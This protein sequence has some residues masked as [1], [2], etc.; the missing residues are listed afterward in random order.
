MKA[1]H[2]GRRRGRG[3]LLLSLLLYLPMA[4]S[5]S[6]SLASC[7]LERL[8]LQPWLRVFEDARADMS[9]EQI[10]ALP[11][12][13]LSAATAHLLAPGY[14]RSAFWLRL[15][16]ENR[17]GQACQW[18]LFP[19]SA[20]ARDMILHQQEAGGWSRQVAG[21]WH[22]LAEWTMPTR[23]PAFEVGLP[24]G[25]SKVLWLRLASDYAF[26]MQPMLLSHTGLL[27]ERMAESLADGLV[28]GIV[29]LLVIFSLALGRIFRLPL[30]VAHAMSMLAYCLNVALA[31]GYGFV[32]LW[33]TAMEW[34]GRAILL[35]SAL[36]RILV[37]AYLRILLLV[38][39]QPPFCGYFLTCCQ[40]AIGGLAVGHALW[41]EVE[42]LAPGAWPGMLAVVAALLGIAGA[43]LVGHRQKLPYDWFCY[44]V[45]GLI[46]LQAL[47]IYAFLFGLASR[48]PAEYSWLSLST[49]YGGALLCYTLVSQTARSRGREQRVL[50]DIEQLKR[51]EQERLE[52][53]V[54]VRTAQ[55]RDSLR[56]QNLLL[57]RI[58]H[59][60]RSP[61][62]G[63]LE[64]ARRLQARPAGLADYS[65][66]IEHSVRHQLELIDELLEYSRGE[67][68]QLELL[69]APGYLFGFLREIEEQGRFLAERNHNR[70]ECHFANDLPPLVNA[71]FRRL[72]QI[73]VNLLANAGK[74]TCDGCIVLYVASLMSVTAGR[75]KLYFSVADSGIGIA[76]A[77]RERLL[78]PFSRGSNAGDREGCG[79]GLY[80]VRQLLGS[81]GS[82][83]LIDES[84]LGGSQFSFVLE[85]DLA[86][87]QQLEQVYIESH[88]AT[89]EGYDRR[90]LIVDD[91]LVSREM[92]RELLAGYGYDPLACGSGEE[93]LALLAAEPVDLLILDQ[94]MPGM[95]GW[96]VLAEVRRCWPD[97]PVLLYS[98]SPPLRPSSLPGH[99]EFDACLLKPANSG[100]LLS[101]LALL[102]PTVPDRAS[103]EV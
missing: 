14:S 63:M 84:D 13:R 102:L 89:G 16:L 35:S 31:T 92:L 57:A 12:E 37:I 38:R 47:L 1:G 100:D 75:V 60:L 55:L 26:V 66:R 29:L 24:A 8:V 68:K 73:L 11:E 64:H 23:L 74:F 21:A 9:L 43:T 86:A 51:A 5:G 103:Q 71:D 52:H 15:E 50:D 28:F 70:L 62:Q 72:R 49:L 27:K 77:E 32:Y 78:E 95:N 81:M 4:W 69:V 19:G 48:P 33:P 97:L 80:I 30:L 76:A 98:A 6:L 59:D 46:L 93:A 83:L 45:P 58:S 79:L 39:Q 99:L 42:L 54:E 56:G 17:T 88:V 40:L 82:R 22:P 7:D 65:R 18:W 44:L 91:V 87:E 85:L 67:L 101:M 10:L 61:L 34:D 90:I 20:R 3:W 2:R 94:L 53:A 25:T 36:T 96:M 41:P